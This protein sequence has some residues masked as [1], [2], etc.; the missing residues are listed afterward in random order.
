MKT[1]P[2][3]VSPKF[4]FLSLGSIVTILTSVIASLTLAFH[5]TTI[6]FQDSA[7]DG[8]TYGFASYSYDGVRTALATVLIFF[9]LTVCIV[10]VW[11]KTASTL[12]RTADMLLRKWMLSVLIF[13]SSLL[14]AIDLVTLVRFFVAGEITERFLYKVLVTL[15]VGIY[16]GACAWYELQKAPTKLG[17]ARTIG[18][19]GIPSLFMIALVVVTFMYIGTP[20]QQ[21][22]LRLDERRIQDLQSIESQLYNFWQ[23][24]ERLPDTL[25]ELT[26]P[27]YPFA[28]IPLDPEFARGAVY[29]YQKTGIL[30]FTLC[31]TFSSDMPTQHLR[32]KETV[33]KVYPESA[34]YTWEYTKG[35]VC[36]TR[37]I[38]TELYPSF[39]KEL[40][41]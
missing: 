5:I 21:R 11:K 2:T 24:K 32:Y 33:R 8:Y 7:F 37:T 41:L 25:S 1:T 26:T 38:D 18:V 22:A 16:V 20:Q 30:D 17:T 28:T 40:S 10:S 13:L 19:I 23:Q 27:L 3:S 6:T 29:E 9:P 34:S 14:V 12:V 15:G 35:R 31:A 4:F 39:K 36:F